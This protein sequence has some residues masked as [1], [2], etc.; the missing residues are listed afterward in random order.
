[1]DL[2]NLGCRD[3][4][5]SGY[6]LCQGE[7]KSLYYLQRSG[8][9]ISGG[10]VLDGTVETIG[11][12]SSSIIARRHS[13]FRGDPDGLMVLDIRSGRVSGPVDPKDIER[14]YPPVKQQSASV[15]WS[16]LH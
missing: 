3:I 7:D 6:A 2:F 8:D 9:A 11:W 15:A 5:Q 13:T 16:N 1:V 14:A 12:D 10:G 4:G